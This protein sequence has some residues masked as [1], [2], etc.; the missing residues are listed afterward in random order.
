MPQDKD[1]CSPDPLEVVF[2]EQLLRIWPQGVPRRLL[3][4]VSGGADSTALAR[5][6]H[7]FLNIPAQAEDCPPALDSRLRGNDE[8]V[9][10]LEKPSFPRSRESRMGIA[11]FHHHLRPQ[12]ADGDEAFVRDL[13]ERLEVPYRR[14]DWVRVERGDLPHSDRNLQAAARR[15]RYHFLFETAK[16]LDIPVLL[17]AHH[18]DDQVETVVFNL[19]RGGGTGAWQGIRPVIQRQKNWILRPLLSVTKRDLLAYLDRIG[20]AHREDS[21]NQSLKYSR[22]RIRHD[23]LPE[24]LSNDPEFQDNLLARNALSQ[25]E[26]AHW[27]KALHPLKEASLLGE[28]SWILP[29]SRFDEMPEEGVFYCI[30]QLLWEFAGA[31]VGWYPVSR[32]PLSVLFGLLRSGE[33]GVV[34]FPRGIRVRLRGGALTLQ[35]KT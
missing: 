28:D 5:L 33:N 15:A 22:N 10:S 13:A 35:R 2:Q 31:E 9:E 12:E 14:G 34:T 21:S 32:K 18:Q 27:L 17:T 11:H 19:S 7:A 1:A 20:E 3:V 6:C 16:D 25:S 23:R 26:E 24:A 30:R 29:R 4:A 8:M